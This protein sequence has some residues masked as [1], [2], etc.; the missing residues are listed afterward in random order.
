MKFEPHEEIA[1]VNWAIRELK[2][3]G[4]KT[5]FFHG[6]REL[7]AEESVRLFNQL[8][9]AFQTLGVKHGM[10]IAMLSRNLPE[11]YLTQLAASHL[12]IRYTPLHPMGS[13]EDHLFVLDDAEI[14]VVV[15]D[16][17]FFSE[18]ADE[19]RTKSA[20]RT[21]VS[22]GEDGQNRDLLSIASL[23]PDDEL[24]AVAVRGGD[25]ETI[26]YTGGTTGTPKGV[27]RT[28]FGRVFAQMIAAGS[29]RRSAAA[30]PV[31]HLI[32]TPIS[33]ASGMGIGPTLM[34]GGAVV[35][36]DGFD[37]GEFLRAVEKF[38][39]TN[40]F[41]VPT[42]IYSLLDYM[43]EHPEIDVS[44]IEKLA[45]GAAPISP[46]RLAEAIE[47]FG[48]VFTQ[49]YGQT[50]AGTGILQ[51]PSADHRLDRPDLLASA[52]RPNPGVAVSI[53]REDG[54]EA[55]PGEVGELCLRGPMVMKG[56]WKR[57]E[58][59]AQAL[60]D[61]WLHTDDMG[62]ITEEGYVTLVDRKKDMI[63]TGGFNV[64]PSEVENAISE[65]PG[66][67]SCAVV[68]RHDEKWGEAVTAYV[69]IHPESTLTEAAVISYVKEKKGAVQTPKSV[70]FVD[71]LPTTPLGKL[72]KRVLRDEFDAEH[73]RS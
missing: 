25:I 21:V 14:D 64:Y 59:T 8:G 53:R 40:A 9:R 48:P 41:L 35:L 47:K 31:R 19:L 56:Y 3:A 32:T 27:A 1:N 42:M 72:N 63:I 36:A 66:V 20:V 10:A 50:E 13:L 43:N 52:G 18:R 4:D 62:F 7:T 71:R 11:T 24:P 29:E 2:G 17:R 73:A 60:R 51:L 67:S 22:L 12:G 5:V 6:S 34:R 58:L 61:G 70:H 68:G 54:T 26:Y 38:R 37:P 28:Y 57:P 65:I 55:D 33:H 39:I 15:Y 30:P 45:Y 44:S 49:G 46:T 23:Q 16:P 69:V